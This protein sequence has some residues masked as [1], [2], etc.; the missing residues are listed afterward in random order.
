MTTKKQLVQEARV[1]Q[2]SPGGDT[3]HP[4]LQREAARTERTSSR[5][6][7]TSGTMTKALGGVL[8][9]TNA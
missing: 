5:T 2:G 1:A 3:S 4:R 6:I 8:L 9:A 7:Q